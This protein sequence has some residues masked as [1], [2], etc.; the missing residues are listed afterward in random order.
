MTAQLVSLELEIGIV[1]RNMEPMRHFYG[2]VLGLPY[3]EL[4]EFPGGRMHRY[5]VGENVVKLVS[6][7]AE[8]VAANPPGGGSAATGLR[9]L[10]LRVGNMREVVEAV[11]AA[12]CEVPVDVTPFGGGIAWA[13]VCDPDGNWVEMFGPEQG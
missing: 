5:S 6:Y 8:P 3:K 7:D 1:T 11:R 12:G 10:S 4:L 2:E 9:Y 13:F